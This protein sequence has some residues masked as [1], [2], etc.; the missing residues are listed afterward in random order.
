MGEK[1]ITLVRDNPVLYDKSRS[2]YMDVEMKDHIWARIA[3]PNWGEMVSFPQLILTSAQLKVLSDCGSQ[4]CKQKYS[5]G[6]N[7]NTSSLYY[8]IAYH[9]CG[10]ITFVRVGILLLL[11]KTDSHTQTSV[12]CRLASHSQCLRCRALKCRH[13]VCLNN[14]IISLAE[15]Q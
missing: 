7:Y 9:F 12:Y 2:D 15:G 1:L 6:C 3:R 13:M 10:L 4:S 11:Y 8:V 5:Y 14:V